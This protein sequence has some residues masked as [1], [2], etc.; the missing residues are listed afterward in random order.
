VSS[1]P[2]AG[3]VEDIDKVSNALA[4]RSPIT[5]WTAGALR[6]PPHLVERLPLID[7]GSAL[8]SRAVDTQIETQ[9]GTL[10]GQ[11]L[12]SPRDHK[13]LSRSVLILD[14]VVRGW[15]KSDASLRAWRN[16]RAQPLRNHIQQHPQDF[17]TLTTLLLGRKEGARIM[18]NDAARELSIIWS[19]F[20]PG[21]HSETT[22][23]AAIASF[24]PID[25]TLDIS[26]P[27][28]AA[29]EKANLIL[30]RNVA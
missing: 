5:I 9:I 1:K 23:L 2:G 6:E 25:R 10:E 16:L 14:A 30:S 24:L 19:E 22:V 4:G 3:Q 29:F 21:K 17:P 28:R 7:Q 20:Q 15:D 13:T 11:L 8:H 18:I 12:L 26:A 27:V